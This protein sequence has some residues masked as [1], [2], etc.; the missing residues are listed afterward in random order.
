MIGIIDWGIGG[1]SI[2]RR[3]RE[4][5]DLPVV[6]FSDTGVTP[7]GKM[8]RTELVRRLDTCIGFLKDA[9]IERLVIGCNAASTAI[10]LLADHGI[11]ID[12]MIEAGVRTCVNAKP[13]K[14][15]LIGGR[16]TVVSGV[17]RRRL[18]EE[19]ISVRQRIAQPLSALIE[20]GDIS[21][22]LLRDEAFK[23]LAPLR[24]CSHILLACT[25]Y[26]AI[27]NVLEK[28]VTDRTRFLD[29]AATLV[30]GLGISSSDR[31]KKTRDRFITTGDPQAMQN[32]A[33]T[34]FGVD[35]GQAERIVL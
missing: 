17:Y 9:G 28:L 34:A 32:A 23:V 7:Y 5:S 8:A 4:R 26:P 24:S 33:K 14:L 12:G 35:I 18:K 31:Q 1:I 10:S 16:R 13:E 30:D 21:S 15:G 29:P 11:K 3:I 19:G 2:Y 20:T 27:E 6:Y 25:H 22:P